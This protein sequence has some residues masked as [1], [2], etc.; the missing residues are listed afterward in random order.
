MKEVYIIHNEIILDMIAHEDVSSFNVS[1]AVPI[2]DENQQPIYIDIK[3]DNSNKIKK[4]LIKNDIYYPNKLIV[5]TLKDCK[6]NE[7]IRLHFEYIVLVLNENYEKIPNRL[8]LNKKKIPDKYK[9]WLKSTESVQSNNIL[10]KFFSQLVKGFSNNVIKIINRIIIY[11]PVHL[12]FLQ[13]LRLI[14]ETNPLLRRIF[15]PKK[16]YTGLMDAISYLFFGGLCAAQT[17]FSTAL[18]RAQGIPTRILIVS[19]FGRVFFT[20]EKTW[21][22]SHHYMME[23]FLPEYGWIK[24]TPGKFPHEPKNYVILRILHPQDENTAGNGLSYYGGMAPWFWI[25]S[26]K[27][28]L[29]FPEIENMMYKKPHGDVSGVP[30]VRLWKDEKIPIKKNK[31]L[32]IKE[33]INKIWN[34][35]V[36]IIGIKLEQSDNKIF[37]NN[38]INYKNVISLIQKNNINR[39]STNL[40]RILENLENI[41]SKYNLK[42]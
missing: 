15:L 26:K 34:V 5:F 38:L 17:N 12:Y 21:L 31:F 18:L 7:K 19:M 24:L 41:I 2:I 35:Y 6:K 1:Y 25:D 30:A 8:Y 42:N 20:G 4:C 22:D 11:T 9:I 28:S 14:L 36:R 37:K 39:A 13:L 10:I 27:I 32:E 33:L 40:E 16:Y 29:V 3:N 23:I